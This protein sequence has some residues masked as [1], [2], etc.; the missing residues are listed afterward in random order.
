MQGTGK[1]EGQNKDEDGEMYEMERGER[2]ENGICKREY[3]G[4][5]EGMSRGTRPLV[6]VRSE[7]EIFL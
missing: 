4:K 2:Q 6:L 5:V 7:K 3:A 1:A